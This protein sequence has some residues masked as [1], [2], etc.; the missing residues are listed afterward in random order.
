MDFLTWLDA[1]MHRHPL[2]QPP[3]TH[4]ARYTAEVMARVKALPTA[5]TP[6]PARPGQWLAWPRLTLAVATG[7]AGFV[8]LGTVVGR[9]PQQLAQPPPVSESPADALVLAESPSSDDQWL[10]ETLQLLEELDEELPADA[11]SDGSEEEWLEELQ[12]LDEGPLA[13]SS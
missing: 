11:A 10:E 9:P 2:Q 6:A 12:L 7:I 1:W 8:L 4:R 3:E 13:A 5:P